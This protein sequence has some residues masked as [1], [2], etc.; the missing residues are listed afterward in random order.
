MHLLFLLLKQSLRRLLHFLCVIVSLFGFFLLGLLVYLF[1]ILFLL[2]LLFFL[3]LLSFVSWL[4]GSL[5]HLGRLLIVFL[6]SLRFVSFYVLVSELRERVCWLGVF[7]FWLCIFSLLIF[8]DQRPVIVFLVLIVF[9]G[10]IFILVIVVFLCLVTAQPGHFIEMLFL[11][12]LLLLGGLLLWWLEERIQYGSAVTI[13]DFANDEGELMTSLVLI[14]H[15]HHSD[16][17]DQL[18]QVLRQEIL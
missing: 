15:G 14:V 1:F 7:V 5:L 12:V 18:V 3:L 16:E 9:G 4:C 2:L 11:L 6:V 13:K 17:F 8:N 10:I